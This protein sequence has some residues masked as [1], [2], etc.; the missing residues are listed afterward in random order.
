MAYIIPADVS[1]ISLSGGHTGEL[2]T[3]DLLKRELPAAYT[4]FHNI[5]WSKSARSYPVFGEIDFIVMNRA[6]RCLLIEQKDGGLEESKDGL[7]KRYS[8]GPKNVGRQLHRSL[9]NV[10]DKFRFQNGDVR[11]D[12]DYLICCPGYHIKNLSAISLDGDRIVDASTIHTLAL[13]IQELVGPD[14]EDAVQAG[15]V[16]R[17]FHNSFELV[18]DVHAHIRSNEKAFTRL[19]GTLSDLITNLEMDPFRLRISGGAGC[20]KSILAIKAFERAIDEGKRPLLLCFNRA[21]REKMNAVTPQGGLVQTWNGLCAKFLENQGYTPDYRNM[22]D[23]PAFWED[24]EERVIA[25]TVP[26]DWIFD[27][28]IVDEGQDFQPEWVDILRLFLK[29]DY[30][31]LWLEDQDQNIRDLEPIELDGFIGYRS[32]SNFRSP[33]SIAREIQ[34]V[35]PFDFELANDLPGLGVHYT[36]YQNPEDQGAHTAKAIERMRGMGFD[37]SDITILSLRGIN[38]SALSERSRVGNFTLSQFTNEYD[39]FGN[40]IMSPGQI[41]FE[42]IFRFKGQQSPAIILTDV[43]RPKGNLMRFRRILYAAMT[44]ATVRLEI[45]H[46]ENTFPC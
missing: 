33:L 29:D 6:G 13:R 41:R 5:H 18:P 10:R 15:T 39:M 22:R 20:G 12:L 43:E 38:S 31:A 3:L 9:D 8:S 45:L 35:L 1:Q 24:L 14:E 7:I 23:N 32:R 25:E 4:V 46:G 40:Q 19:S 37:N 21:L 27:T 28:L 30:D 17:F 2:A 42:S 26:D 11:I 16:E 36:A 44:R 34:R